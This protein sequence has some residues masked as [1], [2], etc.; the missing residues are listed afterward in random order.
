M[1]SLLGLLGGGTR[2]QDEFAAY[3]VEFP[4]NLAQ[5]EM[6]PVR[7]GSITVADPA[8]PGAT[9]EVRVPDLW[10][11]K[12]EVTWD[13]YDIF[14]FKLDLTDQ[15]IAAG[16]DAQSRPSPPYGSPDHG[17][18]R[19]GYPVL[20]VT[21]MAAQKF[22][23]WLTKKTGQ[24]YRL[25]TEAEFEF[26]ARA[27]GPGGPLEAGEL[28]KVAWYWDNSGDQTHACGTKAA[29]ALGLFD[30][31]GNVGEWADDLAGKPV[32]CGGSYWDEAKDVH[33]SA[34]AYQ[35]PKWNETDPQNP[36][37]RWWLSDG[38]FVGFRVV[39]ER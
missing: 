24:T 15:Q 34:R 12:F 28:D 4:E 2:A 1:V 36:K 26:F 23:E 21:H 13:L 6:I 20:H 11:G 7:G 18:G 37:S 25:P 22:C 31:L 5:L 9:R 33:P 35:T 16:V 19:Q 14:L 32:L 30:T 27:G 38:Q 8:N 17:W 3:Q 29:N 39:R 10:V